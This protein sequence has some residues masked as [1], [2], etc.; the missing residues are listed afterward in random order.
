MTPYV[1]P[2]SEISGDHYQQVGG[3]AGRLAELAQ[4][5]IPVP[6]GGLCITTAAYRTYLEET[7]LQSQIMLELVRKAFSDMR[8]EELWDA[9][10]RI[11]N[12]FLT[13]ECPAAL[14][15]ELGEAIEKMLGD[16][17]TAVRSSAP[18]EDSASHSFAGLHESFIGIR[19]RQAI[20]RHVRLVWASLWS[21]RALLY[22]QELEL[23]IRESTMAVLIQPLIEGQASGVAF[24]RHPMADD[25][26]MVEAVWGLNQGL[27]DGDIEPD[28][29]EIDR[30]GDKPPRHQPPSE[31]RRLVMRDG[32][33]FS[34]PVPEADGPPLTDQQVA[35]VVA[36][37]K[38]LEDHFGDPQ[39]TEW[40]CLDSDLVALQTRPITKRAAGE[41]QEDDS[42]AWY[43]TLHRSLENLKQLRQTIT[44][45]VLPGMEQAANEL[46]GPAPDS[47]DDATLA[48]H[49]EHCADSYDK[50]VSTYWETCIPFA[51][52]IR[53]F[54]QVYNDTVAPDD[55]FVFLRLLGGDAMLS[56]RRNQQLMELA[57]DLRQDEALARQL[58]E[59]ETEGELPPAIAKRLEEAIRWSA[60][61]ARDMSRQAFIRLL[62][63]LAERPP[64][65]QRADV[66]ELEHQYLAA[67]PP[68]QQ[69]WARELLQ[70]GRDSYRLR[71]DD[72]LYLDQVDAVRRE[73]AQAARQR[74]QGHGRDLPDGE[75][76]PRD[77]VQALRDPEFDVPLASA[78]DATDPL[79]DIQAR[80]L[81]GQPA[82]AGM[83]SGPCHVVH[84]VSDI[85]EL[86]AGQVLVV[87][88]IGPEMTFALPLAAALVE[89]RGGMLVHGAIVAREY[90]IP[91]VTGIADATSLLKEG[92]WVSVDGHLGIVT[93]TD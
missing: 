21:D 55:P 46:A 28:R 58:A 89:R 26:A 6:P 39:D 12:M 23:D 90:G 85:F 86:Q 43:L 56:I 45:E 51:H 37:N 47:L 8:W 4:A 75:L 32:V 60:S 41:D 2:L 38:R 52:G 29:W 9:A 36:L 72:N 24:G 50:W 78:N 25:Q 44:E 91:A 70:L 35:Q 74:L 93:V 79:S 42:R 92:N 10:L 80:Q 84:E 57:D 11:R 66:A 68:E 62:L 48:D 34:E 3:K 20:L 83:A 7:G 69:E 61:Y 30:Q 71:D 15:E 59:S 33:T 5:G 54:G 1:L 88:A 81:T 77:L 27:V 87:D 49:L 64:A 14:A 73:V 16:Q 40:T 82:S 63:K 53:L 22:R 67:F 18:G 76:E 19:G 31:R 65:K 17:L 13:H